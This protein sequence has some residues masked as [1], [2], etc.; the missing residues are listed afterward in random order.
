[1][2]IVNFDEQLKILYN[3]WIKEGKK[4]GK[5]GDGLLPSPSSW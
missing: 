1:L 3:K 4:K 5:K 2:L